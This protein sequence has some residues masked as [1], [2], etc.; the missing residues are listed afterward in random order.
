MDTA[1]L[2][3]LVINAI[4]QHFPVNQL[5]LPYTAMGVTTL[6]GLI[7]L[8]K[9]ARLAPK[10]LA[11]TLFGA[12]AIG[13]SF[14]AKHW[15][16]PFWPVVGSGAV[17]GMVLGF[18][19][20]R[21]LLAGSIAACA[22][23]G[24]LGAFGVNKLH[25]PLN[26]YGTLKNPLDVTIQAANPTPTTPWMELEKLWGYLSSHPDVPNFQQSFWA[27]VISTGLAGLLFGLLLPRASRALWAA[28][29]GVLLLGV[30]LYQAAERFSPQ[31]LDPLMK[32]A[33]AAWIIVGA[34][35]LVSLLIN[36]RDLREKR[37]L[38]TVD[39]EAEGRVAT[40]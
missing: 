4:T 8:F 16:L 22:I 26:A 29:A 35:W 1:N 33:Q 14:V 28:T 12:G 21:P 10:L 32:N 2:P 3:Q 6:L 15:A 24:S 37:P 19:L 7:L 23:I 30:G 34:V 9:G 25:G 39:D 17:I 38:I 11:L 18:A 27:I 20:F 31:L 36:W 40:A 13:G 5:W